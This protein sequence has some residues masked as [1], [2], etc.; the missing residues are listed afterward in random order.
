MFNPLL[1]SAKN[2]CSNR[3][4][5]KQALSA[6]K[7]SLNINPLAKAIH[8]VC[9]GCLLGVPALV[10]VAHAQDSV[11]QMQENQIHFDIASGSLGQALN[12][13]SSQAGVYLSANANLTKDKESKGLQGK[14]TVQQAFEQ[15]LQGSGLSI[16]QTAKDRFS[17]TRKDRR[18]SHELQA[19][20]VIGISDDKPFSEASYSVTK[21]QTHILDIPQSVSSVNKKVIREHNLMRLNDII[22]YVAGVNEFSVY[23]DLVVRGFRNGDDRRVNGLRTYN[24]GWA[25]INIPH[26]E[27]VEVI[28]GATAATF[29]DSSPGGVINLVTKKPLKEERRELQM[30]L[31]SHNHKYLAGDFTGA[32]NDSK[33]FLYRVN[34]AGEDS[35]SF[36]DQVFHKSK[37]L[38][39][40]FSY[41]PSDDTR[42]NLDLVYTDNETILDRGQQGIEGAGLP[43]TP[44]ESSTAQPGDF[45]DFQT[46]SATISFEQKLADD[47]TLVAKHMHSTYDE[48]LNEHRSTSYQTPTIVETEF[49]DRDTD[50]TVDTTS[51]YVTG[52]FETGAV[53]HKLLFGS[54]FVE[55]KNDVYNKTADNVGTLDVT[56]PAH[57]K[58][59]ISNYEFRVGTWGNTERTTA[60]YLQ[61][62]MS[63][64]SWEFL[65]GLRHDKY[66]GKGYDE[67]LI[68]EKQ[69]DTKLS[70]RLGLVYKLND[71]ASVYGS[72][73]TGFEPA[74]SWNNYPEYGGPF[75]PSESDLL[76]VGYKQMMM[77]GDLLVS[78]AVYKLT[79]TNVV[80]EASHPDHDEWYVQRGEVESKG[81]ELEASGRITQNLSI[82]A[83][84]AWSIA[85]I[86]K[87]TNLN[88]VGKR[89]ENAPKNT[90]TL[91]GRY[92]LN[93]QWGV[94]AGLSYVD[95]RNTWEDNL[96]LP[97]YTVYK[98]GVYY[99][100]KD[101]D[102]SLVGENLTNK[103]HWTGGYDSSQVF[104]G[105]P[106]TIS[107]NV[108]YN[109]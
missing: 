101:V 88:L 14:Y 13:L 28:K 20:E 81:I 42:V 108:N 46:L 105:D 100:G 55:R 5:T 52:M 43:T 77:D 22:P 6:G 53:E 7:Y 57:Y 16:V 29:G 31:G 96:K 109:F 8:L 68:L 51:L 36:R 62:Q 41:I 65:A 9:A 95:E 3:K 60:I 18:D 79:K 74:E 104:P 39:P 70:P 82:I 102:V 19:V 27:R 11:E 69:S 48:K 50:A 44:I 49:Y 45:L 59:D 73:V 24:E 84:Y 32:M 78:A 26:L 103:K 93:D 15:L 34:V 91:W 21:T 76:E 97:S 64:G 85:E 90:A 75:D 4:S 107:L 10:S 89:L 33:T 63:F 12:Q 106:R 71:D 66:Y 56:N 47:W 83:N 72:W 1:C 38:A 58:R 86:S 17:L 30:I 99:S 87:D 40:S 61:D 80:V 23:D 92:A 2:R 98:A 54:D 67:G 35:D 25:Q 37:T 94:G